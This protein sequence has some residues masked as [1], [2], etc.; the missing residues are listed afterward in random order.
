[1]P[2]SVKGHCRKMRL[3][4][5]EF[6]EERFPIVGDMLRSLDVPLSDIID[7]RNATIARL[8]QVLA[9][10]AEAPRTAANIYLD[11][12]ASVIVAELVRHLSENKPRS[13]SDFS[14]KLDLD[15]DIANDHI[16]SHIHRRISVSEVARV[17]GISERHMGRLFRDATGRTVHDYIEH[18]RISHAAHLLTNTMMSVKQI[19]F[20]VGYTSQASFGVAFRRVLGC[21]PSAYR[22][23]LFRTRLSSSETA[24]AS[25]S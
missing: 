9:M 16:R 21:P 25:S 1:M 20:R 12:L 13:T 17:Y 22:Q 14:E 7:M 8:L 24:T 10:E 18:V 19:G 4:R 15:L 2:I 5:L 3:A 6:S 11:G 23:S